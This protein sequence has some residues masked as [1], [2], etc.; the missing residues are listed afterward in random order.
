MREYMIDII[1]NFD[2]R[3]FDIIKY[4]IVLTY[5][6]KTNNRICKDMNLGVSFG[7]T[8]IQRTY[9]VIFIFLK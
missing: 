7:E 8:N 5:K 6:Y 9:W 4:V 2:C 1:I 3:V